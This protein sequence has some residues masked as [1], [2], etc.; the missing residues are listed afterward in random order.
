MFKLKVFH[1]PKPRRF[2]HKPIYW[3]PAK[4]EHDKRQE[5]INSKLENK[6]ADGEYKIGIKRGSFRQYRWESVPETQDMR[7][8]KRQS[9]IRLIIIIMVLLVFAAFLYLS[10][11]DFLALLK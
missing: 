2:Y 5:R 8:Q 4:E 11:G 6:N 7:K 9:N 1:M 3:D 10:S